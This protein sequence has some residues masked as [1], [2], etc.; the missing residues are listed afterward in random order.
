MNVARKT[1]LD[2]ASCDYCTISFK[3][4]ENWFGLVLSP[5]R[6]LV[7]R[8]A[9]GLAREVAVHFG[10]EMLSARTGRA[11]AREYTCERARAELPSGVST[12]VSPKPGVL[13]T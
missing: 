1:L 7:S 5:E 12:K 13:R 9:Q 8:R 2:P 6:G 3:S 4:C 11:T 10:A